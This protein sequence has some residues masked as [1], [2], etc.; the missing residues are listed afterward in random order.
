MA[1]PRVAGYAEALFAVADCGFA[2]PLG[3]DHL[4][5]NTWLEYSMYRISHNGVYI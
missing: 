2:A 4:G 3:I 5:T 1:D